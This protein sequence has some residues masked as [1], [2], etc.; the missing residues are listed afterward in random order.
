MAPTDAGGFSQNSVRM[1]KNA[2]SVL[3]DAVDAQRRTWSSLLKMA[4]P[5]ATWMPRS[6]SQPFS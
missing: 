5:A 4:S 3:P 2:A 6:E 1:G